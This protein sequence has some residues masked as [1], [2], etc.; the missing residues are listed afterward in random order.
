MTEE[1]ILNHLQK[2]K[3]Q[4]V[5]LHGSRAKGIERSSSDWDL[6]V[7]TTEAEEEWKPLIETVY[8]ADLDVDII[9]LPVAND[10]LMEFFGATLMHSKI[11]MDSEQGDAKELIAKVQEKYAKGR[12]VSKEEMESS[13]SHMRRVV[14][15]LQ[16]TEEGSGVFEYH[17]SV[18][19]QIAVQY[20]FE[21]HKEWSRPIY[22]ALP[23]IQEKDSAYHG[24]LSTIYGKNDGVA[25]REAAR[26]LLTLL[27]QH[28]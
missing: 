1:K 9:R 23:F 20:W 17:L 15:R 11:L 12:V 26:Q 13:L 2:Y 6:Y 16:E 27:Q 18:L 7:L 28:V 3:P 10:K 4:A 22:E 8:G 5:I 25:K 21:I 19:Y 14:D 24:H